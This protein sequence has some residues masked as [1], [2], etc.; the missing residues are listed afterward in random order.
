MLGVGLQPALPVSERQKTLHIL[1]R[2]VNIR[3]YSLSLNSPYFLW[4]MSQRP[5]AV[6]FFAFY[7][8]DIKLRTIELRNEFFY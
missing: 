1:T 5:H 7:T 3:V 8:R 6:H 4:A 2:V